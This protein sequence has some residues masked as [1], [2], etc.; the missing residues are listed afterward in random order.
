MKDKFSTGTVILS[1]LITAAISCPAAPA[2]APQSVTLPEGT[3]MVIRL[4]E[5]LDS[6][7]TRQG[8]WF[9]SELMDPVM[10]GAQTVIPKGSVVHG[11]VDEVKSVKMKVMKA[12]IEIVFDRIETPDGR[13]IPIHAGIYKGFDA[14]GAMNK[15]GGAVGEQ[16]ANQALESVTQ[17][18]IMP[19]LIAKK[20]RKAIEFAQKDRNVVLPTG[21]ILEI[22][23]KDPATV[24][25]AR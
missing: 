22:A 14:V 13:A 11:V 1:L 12:K 23:L 9:K 20:A 7:T 2:E 16:V 24:P 25:L 6:K 18:L 4:G 21:S 15:A 8:D 3:K 10:D 5:T 17:G 19:L